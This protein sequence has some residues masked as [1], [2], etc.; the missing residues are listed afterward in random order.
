[1]LE[2]FSV[3]NL[4]V[5]RIKSIIRSYKVSFVPLLNSGRNT[6]YINY[7]YIALGVYLPIKYPI[8]YVLA[9][10]AIEGLL[11]LENYKFIKEINELLDFALNVFREV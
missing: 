10:I 2:I 8:C 1:M 6:S 3:K 7:K 9:Y 4:V 5:D 11:Y